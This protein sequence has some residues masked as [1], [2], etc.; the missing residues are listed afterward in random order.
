MFAHVHV[1]ATVCDLERKPVSAE[2]L[3]M[4]AAWLVERLLDFEEEESGITD[5]AVSIEGSSASILIRVLAEGDNADGAVE[6]F[7]RILEQILKD[8]RSS[9]LPAILFDGENY[10]IR[11]LP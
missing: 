6:R 11:H 1:R 10:G 2:D 7:R 3:R 8:Q 4:Q 9:G 5:T